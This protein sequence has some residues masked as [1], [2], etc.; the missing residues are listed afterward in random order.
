M[1]SKWYIVFLPKLPQN[2]QEN[3]IEITAKYQGKNFL[4]I[5]IKQSE[6]HHRRN[7][8]SHHSLHFFDYSLDN[9]YDNISSFHYIIFT[10]FIRIIGDQSHQ[11][12]HVHQLLQGQQGQKSFLNNF[13]HWL[14][15]CLVW[16]NY[17]Q[18]YWNSINSHVHWG[19]EYRK[20]EIPLKYSIEVLLLSKCHLN[21]KF[22]E[23]LNN[24]SFI[25]IYQPPPPDSNVWA[26]WFH[27]IIFK[28]VWIEF[29]TG[30]A[31]LCI[32]TFIL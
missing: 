5:I 29:R 12:H 13:A 22:W 3:S 20:V 1:L 2:I 4:K 23:N 31:L 6:S 14:D 15:I 25:S 10:A 7:F 18:S 8:T 19:M 9:F 16:W 27:Q 30:W 11:D 26:S 32:F 17:S 24:L 28:T 21:P